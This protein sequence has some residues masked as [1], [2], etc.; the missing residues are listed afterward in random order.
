MKVLM[1]NSVCGVGSTGRIA[2]DLSRVLER[3]GHQSIVAYG[4]KEPMGEVEHIRIGT[5]LDVKAHGAYARL[6]DRTGFGSRGATKDF[7]LWAEAY[8][9]DLIH[10]HNLHGYY[11][12]VGLLFDYLRKTGKPVVWTLHDCWPFTGHCAYFDYVGCGRWREGCFS[13]PQKGEYPASLLL[14]NSKSNY[15]KKR[16]LF[17]GLPRMTVVTPSRFLGS[18]AR[19]SFLGEYP[20]RVIPNGI[21]LETF[22]PREGTAR[23]KYGLGDGPIVLGVANVWE[24]RKGLRDFCQLAELLPEEYTVALVGLSPQQMEG[25]PAKIKGIPRTDSTEELAQLYSLAQVF[26]NPTW[27]D[28]FPTTNLEALACGTP[29]ITYATG[30]SPE[31][32]DETCGLTVNK[33]DVEALA[34]GIQ[35]QRFSRESCL[36]RSRRFGKDGMFEAY[37]AL[38]QAL[39]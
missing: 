38:Y 19:E 1:I 34:R 35:E 32:L 16:A 6:L 13:C 33:G 25:L 4:R 24:D 9:P 39:L 20:L 23:E 28:N 26:V 15:R 12:H 3:E 36:A 8:D 17:T 18:L 37:L 10:L 11:L 30:G 31:A 5:D 27:E 14:D 29:V 21:D 22:R 7:L 2:A